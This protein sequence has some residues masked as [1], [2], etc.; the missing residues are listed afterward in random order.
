M[1]S[2][3]WL[4]LVLGSIFLS[5]IAGVI[6]A[7]IASIKARWWLLLTGAWIAV[8]VFLCWDFYKHPIVI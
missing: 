1:D 6:L 2:D 8:I 5:P 4:I 7:S 3:L